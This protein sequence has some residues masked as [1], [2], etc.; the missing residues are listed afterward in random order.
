MKPLKK[1]NKLLIGTLI[2]V[3]ILIIINSHSIKEGASLGDNANALRR[4]LDGAKDIMS[5]YVSIPP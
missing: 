1:Y 5:M 3:L 4:F 2:I